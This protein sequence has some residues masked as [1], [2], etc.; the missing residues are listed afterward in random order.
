ML[1]A[2]THTKGGI[3]RKETVVKDRKDFR[4]FHSL[5]H[6]KDVVLGIS[7]CDKRGETKYQTMLSTC[8]LLQH[9]SLDEPVI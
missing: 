7:R 1:S 6:W 5:E 3:E 2:H 9:S 8:C 4:V